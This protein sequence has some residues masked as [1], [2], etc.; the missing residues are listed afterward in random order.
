MIAEILAFLLAATLIGAAIAW[1][2]RGLRSQVSERRLLAE[3]QEVRAGRDCAEA[4]VRTLEVA[5][6]DLR[7]E[8][9]R[10]ANR[11]KTRLAQLEA[12]LEAPRGSEPAR[13][14]LQ[15]AASGVWQFLLR[16]VSGLMRLF[17][18]GR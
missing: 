8:R 14:R 13:A 18:R 9:E 16:L 1:L 6:A 10:E 17:Q 5:L 3:L 12:L 15:N 2:L 7:L 4:A 11:L